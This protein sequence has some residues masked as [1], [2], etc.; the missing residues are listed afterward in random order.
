MVSYKLSLSG[1]DSIHEQF[2]IGMGWHR[3]VFSTLLAFSDELYTYVKDVIKL[4]LID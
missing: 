1:L 2:G 4:T 3:S